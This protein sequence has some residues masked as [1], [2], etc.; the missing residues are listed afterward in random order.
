MP[1][2]FLVIQVMHKNHRLTAKAQIHIM[3]YTTD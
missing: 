2:S 3:R 1:V